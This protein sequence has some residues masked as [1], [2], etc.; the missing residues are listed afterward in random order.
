MVTGAVPSSVWKDAHRKDLD[1]AVRDLDRA[2]TRRHD[3]PWLYR[4]RAHFH[5]LRG[6]PGLA[7]GDFKQA[8]IQ[9]RRRGTSTQLA[10]DYVELGHL[11]HRAGEYQAALGSFSQA[12][13]VERDYPPAH[14]QR[15][16]T[17]LRLNRDAEA[18]Q[19]LDSY[20]AKGEPTWEAYQARGLIHVKLVNYPE[21]V[22]AFNRALVLKQDAMT[23]RVR[24]WIYLKLG[25][26]P[27]ALRDFEAA[28][29]LNAHDAEALCGRGLARARLGQRGALEDAAAA[30]RHGP[31]TPL[32]LFNLACIRSQVAGRMEALARTPEAMREMAQEQEMAVRRVEDALYAERPDKRS[33]F[34]RKNI[35]PD[36]DLV[37]IRRH[38]RMLE[39]ARR[40]G[41]VQEELRKADR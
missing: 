37:P 34:W 11:Q 8:I 3:H 38:P 15:A 10:S 13:Q 27:L 18:G 21:A 31:R 23:L 19:A 29:R 39:L 26:T 6:K 4:A 24:G 20:L 17:L 32:F 41:G 36:A 30:L 5:L 1:D 2:L 28:L 16:E 40:F 22:R 35:R 14:R 9:E 12:L 7:Q 25:A 33:D